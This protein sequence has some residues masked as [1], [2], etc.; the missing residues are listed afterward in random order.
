MFK[1]K[2]GTR[3]EEVGGRQAKNKCSPRPQPR[4]ALICL[5]PVIISLLVLLSYACFGCTFFFIVIISAPFFPALSPLYLRS[6][7]SAYMW[8]KVFTTK[9]RII[10]LKISFEKLK[11]TKQK[12]F[13]ICFWWGRKLWIIIF[14]HRMY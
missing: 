2:N 7:S 3:E 9:K 5:R 14:T 6:I 1:R 12:F 13:E 4:F 11:K 8:Q 10:N